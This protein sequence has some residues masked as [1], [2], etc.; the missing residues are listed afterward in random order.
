ME[1]K[2]FQE[3]KI[4]IVTYKKKECFITQISAVMSKSG[5]NF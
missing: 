3:K 5:A 4:N 1:L 2:K